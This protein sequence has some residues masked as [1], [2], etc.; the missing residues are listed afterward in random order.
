MAQVKLSAGGGSSSDSVDQ[1]GTKVA[2]G[3]DAALSFVTFA[4]GPRKRRDFAKDNYF[5]VPREDYVTGNVTGMRVAKEL[6]AYMER[7]QRAPAILPSIFRDVAVALAED[8]QDGLGRRGAAVGFISVIE[9]MLLGAARAFDH[10]KYCQRRITELEG[11]S[12]EYA[13]RQADEKVA[14]RARMVAG[15]RAKRAAREASNV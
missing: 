8:H 2:E 1:T 4:Y 15:K 13:Q 7:A 9:S 6:M 3:Y 5:A 12:A 10:G 11:Y 14:F